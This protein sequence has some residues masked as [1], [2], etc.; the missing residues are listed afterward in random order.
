MA[1][2]RGA[3][4]PRA[5][6]LRLDALLVERGLAADLRAAGALLLAG[7][8]LQDDAPAGKA[9][10]MVRADVRLRLR[11]GPP[12]PFVSRAGRKLDQAL[13][14]FGVDLAGRVVADLGSS[15]GGFVDCALRRGARLVYAIDVGYGQLDWGL[16]QDPRVVVMERTNVRTLDG[17]PTPAAR[18][19]GDL[20][21]ISLRLI[22]PVLRRLGAPEGEACLLIKPQFEVEAGALAAGGRLRDPAARAAAIAGVLAEAEAEGFTVLGT[23]ASS[24][25]GAKAGNR[26]E[27]VHLRWGSA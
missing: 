19:V 17:L 3:P 11:G 8:V 5:P 9:G 1:G 24:V 4:V 2:G 10:A 27:L 25:P 12:E 15:T 16:R 7:E 13:D 18:I 14:H 23:V 26:E 6:K 22:L 21:F 20:S